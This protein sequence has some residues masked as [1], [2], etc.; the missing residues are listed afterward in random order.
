MA[1]C[2]IQ[3]YQVSPSDIDF[4]RKN[5]GLCFRFSSSLNRAALIEASDTIWYK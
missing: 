5:I 3:V 2:S 1:A 4:L